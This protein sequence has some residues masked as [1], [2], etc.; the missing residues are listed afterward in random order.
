MATAPDRLRQ[1]IQRVPGNRLAAL[2]RIEL[3]AVA[4][5]PL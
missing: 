3:R 2:D 4:F 1:D 5:R